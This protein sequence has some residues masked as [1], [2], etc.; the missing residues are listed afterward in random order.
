MGSW[1]QF[2]CVYVL[3]ERLAHSSSWTPVGCPRIQLNPDTNY[4]GT[5]SDPTGKGLSPPRLPCTSDAR[6]KL[7]LL[8]TGC[9]SEGPTTPSLD[10][11]N[12]L[13]QLTELR[14]PVYSLDYCFIIK[15][16]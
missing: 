15:D 5:A 7:R 11:I 6:R 3:G 14:K 4:L 8:P 12:F 1:T 9:K 13:K 16:I 10:S 2:Q